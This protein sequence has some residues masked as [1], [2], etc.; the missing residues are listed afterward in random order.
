MKDTV[1]KII[2]VLLSALVI[3]FLGSVTAAAL[4]IPSLLAILFIT[5]FSILML[6]TDEDDIPPLRK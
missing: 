4:R 1:L 2:T 5:L 3:M 6:Y